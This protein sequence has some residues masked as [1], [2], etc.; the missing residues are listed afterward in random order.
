ML[1]RAPR[2]L[3]HEFMSE[4]PA[5]GQVTPETPLVGATIEG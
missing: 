2:L 4:L 3:L 1:V 5:D